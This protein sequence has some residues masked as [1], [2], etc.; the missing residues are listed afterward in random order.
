MQCNYVMP[1]HLL[2]MLQGSDKGSVKAKADFNAGEDVVALRK[3]IEG[4]GR[5]IMHF[6]YVIVVWCFL[7]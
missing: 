6:F 7:C 2:V 3:A 1:P 5:L 4:L